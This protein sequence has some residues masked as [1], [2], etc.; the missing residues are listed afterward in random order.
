MVDEIWKEVCTDI[1]RKIEVSNL[2]KLKVDGVF[3]K[4]KREGDTLK[5][6]VRSSNQTGIN[7]NV[8]TLIID[9]LF[10]ECPKSA[11]V[12]KFILTHQTLDIPKNTLYIREDNIL[13]F[14]FH[15][16][17]YL[18]YNNEGLFVTLSSNFREVNTKDCQV[19]E[20]TPDNITI[21]TIGPKIIRNT[22]DVL[23]L[24]SSGHIFSSIQN[25]ASFYKMSRSKM[26]SLI[27]E[28]NM[29]IKIIN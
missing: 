4:I 7:L 20:A 28:K 16:K 24:D 1:D 19:I 15:R 29:N 5:C 2:I 26:R 22:G 10:N 23:Y 14:K 6:S 27:L 11:E 17:L 9:N 3:R 18:V 13:D 21:K 12:K 8:S 25:L